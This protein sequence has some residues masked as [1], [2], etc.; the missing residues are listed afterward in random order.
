MGDDGIAFVGGPYG[1][2]PSSKAIAIS[3]H[4]P[5]SLP[6]IFFGDGP[7]FDMAQR[8]AEFSECV[9]I[10]FNSPTRLV[11][12]A[13]SSFRVIIFVNTTRFISP[14]LSD[15]RSVILVE[16]LGWLRTAQLS[17]SD[18]I[19]A[20]FAQVFFEH[21]FSSELKS[22]RNFKKVGAIVPAAISESQR[23]HNQGEKVPLVHCGGLFSPSMFPGADIV[24]VDHLIDTLAELHKPFRLV[25]PRH[26][27]HIY[28]RRL[29]FGISI[30][31]CSPYPSGSTSRDRH[32]RLR[33]LVLSLRMR[34]CF[35]DLQ[36]CF[37]LRSIQASFSSFSTISRLTAGRCHLTWTGPKLN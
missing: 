30:I 5:R 8:S 28:A 14:D 18:A 25:L 27:H 35:L 24:F 4:L 12:E 31:D 19:K 34:A 6:R 9:R 23:P 21:P 26:L 37:F 13:L 36:H 29:P 10:D 15:G 22:M 16:T 17:C 11:W 7:P 3:S 20:Y 32:F 1:Y 2:G 33:R